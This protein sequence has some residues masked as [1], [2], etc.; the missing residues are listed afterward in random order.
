MLHR[1]RRW[2]KTLSVAS[3]R[4]TLK[5]LKI[6]HSGMHAGSIWQVG[7][8]LDI[9]LNMLNNSSEEGKDG[10]MKRKESWLEKM[11]A[12][13]CFVLLISL[14]GGF[15]THLVNKCNRSSIQKETSHG[16]KR[17]EGEKPTAPHL[18]EFMANVEGFC[19]QFLPED[20]VLQEKENTKGSVLCQ[21]HS[22]KTSAH[23]WPCTVLWISQRV[24]MTCLVEKEHDGPP[25][26]GRISANSL[27]VWNRV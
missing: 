24:E 26:N 27:R 23:I 4:P 25:T 7:L 15:L 22:S 16:P 21:Y 20:V 10:K 19:F 5:T 1:W 13:A 3:P 17:Q 11:F 8:K 9:K 2:Y 18:S 14:F 6:A 12:A